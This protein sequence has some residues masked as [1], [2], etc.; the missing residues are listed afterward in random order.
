MNRHQLK[1]Q[2]LTLLRQFDDI[3]NEDIAKQ[4]EDLHGSFAEPEKTETP[5][6][7]KIDLLFYSV[8]RL[9]AERAELLSS[10][11]ALINIGEQMYGRLTHY[12]EDPDVAELLEKWTL[13]SHEAKQVSNSIKIQDDNPG[14]HDTQLEALKAELDQLH[15]A[16]PKLVSMLE[17]MTIFDE[18]AQEYDEAIDKLEQELLTNDAVVKP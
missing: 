4:L 16:N 14:P 6:P 13:T 7:T 3:E 17:T 12:A 1:G 10:N 11:E 15:E 5:S 9:E 18:T 2:L 8:K